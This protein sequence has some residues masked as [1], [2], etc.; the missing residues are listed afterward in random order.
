MANKSVLMG[1]YEPKWRAMI[2]RAAQPREYSVDKAL[3]EEDI[4]RKTICNGVYTNYIASTRFFCPRGLQE[5]EP[6]LKIHRF[7]VPFIAVGETNFL[8]MTNNEGHAE[9]LRA[10]GLDAHAFGD[11]N[12]NKLDAFL[13]K[14][15]CAFGNQAR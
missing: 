10:N 2:V 15:V 8:V 7:L 12:K 6:L 1:V 14:N 5:L 9:A 13:D 11:F 3:D 4:L